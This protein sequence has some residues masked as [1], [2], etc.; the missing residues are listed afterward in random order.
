MILFDLLYSVVATSL[1]SSVILILNT[2]FSKRGNKRDSEEIK[3]AVDTTIENMKTSD[4][5][6]DLMIKNVAELRE[7]Y[8]ISKQQANKSFSSALLVCFLGFVVFIT[9]IILNYLGEENV[10][11]FTTIA[12]T[13]VEVVAGLFFGYIKIVLNNSI[14]IMNVWVQQRSI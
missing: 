5:V 6:L 11:L 13:I 9:G 7:Y 4:N 12:G 14:C 10:V 1:S 2:L 8:I 3:N